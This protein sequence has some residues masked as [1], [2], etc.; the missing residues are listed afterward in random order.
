[1][2]I[3]AENGLNAQKGDTV[4]IKAQKPLLFKASLL[5]YILPLAV[6]LLGMAIGAIFGIEWLA[7]VLFFAGLL[8]GWG[9]LAVFDR[10]IAKRKEYTPAVTEILSVGAGVGGGKETGE[11]E[12]SLNR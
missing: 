10:L 2:H 9:V 1:M 12:N 6:A 4:R 7:I 11:E 8:V 3:L 5:C